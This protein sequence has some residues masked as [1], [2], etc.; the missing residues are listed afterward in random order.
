MTLVEWL[1]TQISPGVKLYERLAELISVNRGSIMVE[2]VGNVDVNTAHTY[3]RLGLTWT[4][5]L[6][7]TAHMG[8]FNGFV[9][10]SGDD[11]GVRHAMQREWH[12]QIQ[13][14]ILRVR[15]DGSRRGGVLIA[16]EEELRTALAEKRQMDAISNQLGKGKTRFIQ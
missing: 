14:E 9:L 1:E 13:A 2:S 7:L 6:E 3:G 5:A 16:T 12:Q 11:L 4:E 8:T 10:A 15:E